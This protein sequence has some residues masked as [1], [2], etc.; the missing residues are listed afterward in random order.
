MTAEWMFLDNHL[1]S[2]RRTVI[3]GEEHKQ[4]FE[5]ASV[6]WLNGAKLCFQEAKCEIGLVIW[7]LRRRVAV[8]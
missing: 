4:V 5:V 6:I 2:R 8:T 7:I 3:K 1:A